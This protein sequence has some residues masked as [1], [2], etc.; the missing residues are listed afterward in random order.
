MKINDVSE[1]YA[2]FFL[3]MLKKICK[4]SKYFAGPADP[5]CYWSYRASS[6]LSL[7]VEACKL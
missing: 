6:I 7:S 1:F 4:T 5:R 2:M 3:E